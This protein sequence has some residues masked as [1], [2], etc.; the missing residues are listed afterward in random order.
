MWAFSVPMGEASDEPDHIAYAAYI[1]VHHALPPYSVRYPEG[2]EPPLYYALIAPLVDREFI[3]IP[4]AR[5]EANGQR[6][7]LHP[8]AEW[9]HSQHE[10]AAYPGLYGA[11]LLTVVF[12]LL[13][14]AFTYLAA[15]ELANRRSEGLLAAGAV[16]LL[17]AF[18]F[19]GMTISCDALVLTLCAAATWMIVCLARKG[20]SWR[21]GLSAAL[22][23]AFAGLAKATGLM[24]LP[25]LLLVLLTSPA[26]SLRA[27]I[28]RLSVLAV[29]PVVLAPYLLRNQFLYGDPFAA[30]AMADVLPGLM[31]HRSLFSDYFVGPFPTLVV[32]SFL[33]RFGW[34]NLPLPLPVLVI[35]LIPILIGVAALPR[36]LQRS[37]QRLLMLVLLTAPVVA[38][39]ALVGFNLKVNQAAAQGRYLFPAMPAMAVLAAML[40]RHVP[41]WA[42]RQRLLLPAALAGYAVLNLTILLAVVRPAYGV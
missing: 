23:V 35:L 11:R 34:M 33:G 15:R 4:D 12:S 25:P 37:A 31:V 29:V 8:P 18:S 32:Q 39:I 41:G 1:H 36:A 10:V 38:L 19:R 2:N 13:S 30:R 27:R 28:G 9:K 22:L 40:Y 26:V 21:L 14:V 16:A 42:A 5:V 3:T 20:F 6:V 24:L 17:P 7:L